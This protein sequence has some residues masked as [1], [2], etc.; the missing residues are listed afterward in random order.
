MRRACSASSW[1]SDLALLAA[2]AASDDAGVATVGTGPEGDR[3]C[4]CHQW[5]PG[6]VGGRRRTEGSDAANGS[7]AT[8]SDVAPLLPHRWLGPPTGIRHV[9]ADGADRRQPRGTRRRTTTAWEGARRRPGKA[10]DGGLPKRKRKAAPGPDFPA[11]A[12]PCHHTVADLDGTDRGSRV[13]DDEIVTGPR[14]CHLKG[15]TPPGSFRIG[16][17]RPCPE[18]C[19][20]TTSIVRSSR[21][22][23]GLRVPS[24][25][26]PGDGADDWQ[27]CQAVHKISN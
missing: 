22:G 9:R 12:S 20:E 8:R 7:H 15:C 11:P 2:S 1:A 18:G 17:L 5:P 26:A 27:V 19:R 14:R 21:P 25:G 13:G 4:P 16:R 6:A 23:P 24:T 3:A 10:H